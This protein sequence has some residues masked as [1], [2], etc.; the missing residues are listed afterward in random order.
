MNFLFF[1]KV[2]PF[3]TDPYFFLLFTFV[4]VVYCVGSHLGH[5]EYSCGSFVH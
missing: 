1:P 3:V 2:P 4:F 5:P